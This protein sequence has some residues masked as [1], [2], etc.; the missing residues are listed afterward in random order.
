MTIIT[1]SRKVAALAT[2]AALATS[3]AA[4][5][6]GD[7]GTSTAGTS[8]S[9]DGA[10]SGTVSLLTPIFEGSSGKDLLAEAG[11]DHPPTTVP[12]LRDMAK[13]LTVRDASGTMT[14]AGFDV[15]S[16]DPRQVFETVLF[17]QGGKLFNSD[18]T[19]PEF[20]SPAGVSALQ[21]MTNLFLTDK[22]EDVG[23][24]STDAT[25]NPLITG[26]PP[27]GSPLAAYGA[28]PRQ[29]TRRC[30]PTSSRSSSPVTTRACS[31][32]APS[33]RC[34]ANRRA[35]RQPRRCSSQGL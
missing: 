26:A 1:T 28:R 6:S 35:P 30:S 10:V 27:W 9:G 24:S 22:V 8:A 19:K 29:L 3:L 34:R 23:F 16:I 31:L 5:G 14:R 32:A 33:R 11:F 15:Q 13:A 7:A 2:A 21:L 25:V 20:N 18:N 12:E 17:S 4:C